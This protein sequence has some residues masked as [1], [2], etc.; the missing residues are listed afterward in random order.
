VNHT[1][2]ATGKTPALAI[3][4]LDVSASMG[5][6]LGN[7][8]RIE[9]V[10]DALHSIFRR[11]VY[12]STRGKKVSPRY[13]MAIYA[14]SDEVFDILGGIKSIEQ[15]A[16]LGAPNPKPRLTTDTALGFEKVEELLTN[17]LA[18]YAHCPAPVICHLT[19]GEYTGE[20]PEPVV[21]RI[22][23]LSV[24]DG[25]VLVENIFISDT[26]LPE[27]ITDVHKWPGILADNK[28]SSDYSR[29]LLAMSSIL[30]ETYRIMM[31]EMGYQIRPNTTMLLP[32]TSLEL[33][34]LAFTMATTTR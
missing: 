20:D 32:G 13:H 22:M 12:L 21:K 31:S 34:T 7:K 25:P 24:S 5:L 26:I 6:P 18:N 29:K 16:S 17:E 15:V 2:Q 14:Y 28:M 27:P 33:V 11:M 30:P 19:D 8:T 23:Q 1:L 4:L 3:F 10:T 9:I